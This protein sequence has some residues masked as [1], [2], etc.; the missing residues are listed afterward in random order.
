[1]KK[2]KL[3][4]LTPAELKLKNQAETFFGLTEGLAITFERYQRH[5]FI[6]QQGGGTDKLLILLQ[7]QGKIYQ[8]QTN[9]QQGIIHFLRPGDLIGE[10]SLLEVERETKAVVA[11]SQCLCLSMPIKIAREKLLSDANFQLQL[12]R[13]LAE[14]LLTRTDHLSAGLNYPLLNRLA[15]FILATADQGLYQEK[16][17]EA[18]D[19]LGVSY[20]HLLYTF[21][22]LRELGLIKKSGRDYQIMALD[23]ITELA[24][25]IKF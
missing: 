24:Q 11:L 14:K 18:A 22:Q 25:G 19:Y 12:N 15:A 21:K 3:S 4:E 17:G 13:Y 9:G 6:I 16:H 7:G 5:E 10:L 2:I 8:I 1:M 23:K 20:R